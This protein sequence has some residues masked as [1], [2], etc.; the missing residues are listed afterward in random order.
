MKLEEKTILQKKLQK[1]SKKI[2]KRKRKRTK[3]Y[4]KGFDPEIKQAMPDPER[5]LPKYERKSYLRK[6]KGK[7]TRT[8]GGYVKKQAWKGPST[9]QV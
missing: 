4:P 9:S 3:R 1:E 2:K 8:Q 5:W 7:I 6:H